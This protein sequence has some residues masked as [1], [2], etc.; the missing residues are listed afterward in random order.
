MLYLL[1]GCGSN[2][3]NN[4]PTITGDG[5]N[6]T[7]VSSTATV[8]ITDPAGTNIYSAA[9]VREIF[10][11]NSSVIFTAFSITTDPAL[12]LPLFSINPINGHLILARSPLA[13]DPST[14]TIQIT[15][16]S[17]NDQ[18]V[19]ATATLVINIDVGALTRT[20][21]AKST[22]FANTP[23][24]TSIYTASQ[25][26]GSFLN[27]GSLVFSTFS[28][29][30]TP[31]TINPLFT[32]N[33]TNGAITLARIPTLA[34]IATQTIAITAFNNDDRT[35]LSTATLVVSVQAGVLTR[36][37]PATATISTNALAGTSIY[38]ASQVSG[39][40]LNDG[41][42]VF[43]TFSISITPATIN[44]LFTI[45]STNGAITLVRSPEAADASTQTILITAFAGTQ[46][47]TS[48]LTVFV[49][50]SAGSLARVIPA[51]AT[52][53]TGNPVGT[54][55]YTA[56]QVSGSFLNDGSLVFSTFS[57]SITPATIN[58]LFTINSTNGA[59]TLARIPTLADIATQTIAIT[60][61]NNDDRTALSTATLVVSV[62][63][64]VLTRVIPA[65]ATI[66]T[67]AL[68]GTS[69]YTASQVS[70]SFLNDGS[71]NFS[72]FSIS[73]TPS[74]TNPLF[75]INATNGAITLVRSPEAADASTQTILITAFAGT[76]RLTSTLTVFV[77]VSAGSLAR[78]IPATATVFTGNPVGT[79]IYTASQVSGSF[80][81]DG[82]LVF[83][84][85]SISI[86]PA[87][88][89][90]LFTI[91][92]T[93][94]AITLAR[95]PTLADI[96][97]QTIAITA[98][99]NDDRT[100]LSTAT[101]VVSV[102]AGVLT[103]VIPATAT[104]STNALAGTSIYTASQVSGSF[105]NDGSLNFSTFS[106][107]VTPST[108]NPLF[109]IN[110]TNGAITLV[111]SPE[112]AD[113]STQTILITAF[114]GTQRL[115]S[116]LTVFVQV[117][118]GSLARVIPA[119]ATVFTDN[120]VGTPIY[121]A[122]QV[123]GSFLND[124][125]LVFSTF[126]ISI[127]PATINPLFTINS[128]NGAI[129]LARIPTL[130]DIAT[131]TIAITAF[132]N[133]D[134]TGL[135]TATLVVSVQAGVLT[136][137]IPAT[138]T[139][140]TNALAGTSIYT[141]S[142]VSGSFL[143]D[144]SLNFSTFSIS[145]TPSTTN[146]L[147][148]INATN[149][150]I[151][152]VRSPEA[153]DAST[154]TILITAFA[155]TQRL[156]ST[157]TVFVQVSAGSLARVIPAT[158]TV[159][160]G[161]PVGTPIYTASQVSGSF[162][163]DGSLVFSTFSISITPAT[164]NPLFTINST[165][166]AIT[167]ARIPTLADIAT[168][169]IA[170]TA[171]NNDD[172]T[173]LSTATLV[174]S[175]QAGTLTR[176][177]PATAT[178][179]TNAL[180]GASIYTAS[181]VSGSFLNDGSLNFSTFSISVTPSTTNPLFTINATN[182]AI[183]L[184][185]SPEAADA[186]TQTILITAFAGTQRLTS[187]LTV[188]VQVSA[189]SLARVIPATATVFTGNPV[190]T[191]IYTAS[192]VSGS[193]L[194]DGSLVFSTFSISITP[195]TINPLFTINSTNGAITLARIP[196]LADIAT[197]TIAITAFNNDDRTALSTATLVVSVLP[198]NVLSLTTGVKTI[199][200]SWEILPNSINHYQLLT[201]PEGT[202]GFIDL[203][204][205]GVIVSPNSTNITATTA[206]ARIALHK[207]FAIA[208]N[209]QYIVETCASVDNSN[210]ANQHTQ[211]SL[212]NAQV[213]SLIE[214]FSPSNLDFA[215]QF[216]AA[217]S[218]SSDGN[219]FVVGAFSEDGDSSS[220]MATPN[221]NALNSGAAYVFTRSGNTWTQT[222]YLKASNTGGGIPPNGPGDQFGVS[223]A[224]SAD[225]S[226]IVVG[227]P[228]EDG[229]SNSSALNPNE[230][231]QLAGAAYVFSRSGSVWSQTAYLKATNA[232][233]NAFF[234]RSV[235][236]NGDG[237]VLVV[238][239]NFANAFNGSAYVF[240]RSGSV[241]SQTAE[242]VASNPSVLDEFGLTVRINNAG[243]V[244]AIGSP[245]EDGSG[246]S[247]MAVPNDSAIDAGAVY[248]YARTST[249]IPSWT[250]TAYI[251]ASNAEGADTNANG[252]QFGRSIDFNADGSILV[253]NAQNED[254]S[255]TSTMAMPNNSSTDTGSAYVFN[256]SGPV[257]STTWTQTA[258]VKAP[259]ADDGDQFG[260]SVAI[261]GNSQILLIGTQQENSNAFSGMNPSSDNSLTNAGAAYTY[262]IDNGNIRFLSF[263]KARISANNEDFGNS[264]ALDH[265]GNNAIV[266]AP[267]TINALGVASPADF[268][269]LY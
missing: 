209:P 72:T 210:C 86:T 97:T 185:R 220:T 248:I 19:T 263:L 116:T 50:V 63:A 69:I 135:S 81:N 130:A 90:P 22:I 127:T 216:G 199:N 217:V 151:T 30:I 221:D 54:P 258:Y 108:T 34:D 226:I 188:F 174:V 198:S 111:R 227:A 101:L 6:S 120:P 239:A 37:I 193:F 17:I 254:G 68:A 49:Q 180:A 268:V 98:F 39:S 15:A 201:N 79:P 132:N 230:N 29:S 91:N 168:Q 3:G 33:S 152:L 124:G 172:R 223:V 74:T 71:L 238:G 179:S 187:T 156:T 167:L 232:S 253:V 204:T 235:S 96:A 245:N 170:I 158:A 25:V 104:I 234:G 9:Q 95:I 131:Q 195:A 145:V 73:V 247:S 44:P 8:S 246:T 67:N 144:G 52:V 18:T 182:G 56:S 208:N 228:A 150:A 84:T 105:L 214:Q 122:S 48:T 202:S 77:Q 171:F 41:S 173:A 70:G 4:N 260:N 213:R 264:A 27:D 88:I 244:I 53:F 252:D 237:S 205:N 249:T 106:I 94:G 35:A 2:N 129:T 159:F 229:D 224:I 211:R 42:L 75:T 203:S 215:D 251:K 55:I 154:Q 118:A 191:P 13:A 133:D 89:N 23:A 93:N 61:F 136:R 128:T 16:S 121:T 218:I 190:G 147:F 139:I 259:N 66:S 40:F 165:N 256:R 222:G 115:T 236:I 83:S 117:S 241:W 183:T 197:Q 99:N 257:T 82:S 78:V 5:A 51:T 125:S 231:A 140:S 62:Q 265:S 176:V 250:Q 100:A 255:S 26:S 153:A 212:T 112:A 43:S 169:T 134:R 59:I 21:P 200:F 113:A 102:Q 233:F 76:Q 186:S 46:R 85:F 157:L 36:V 92:S 161:N 47:L 181:Q 149:G 219:T 164:I 65:T 206:S 160:T 109:T 225:G 103:R 114:A 1:Q 45:N 163:N 31:A 196:T 12:T 57:I 123:S 14:H 10:S 148:T 137:V 138:A 267:G 243:T 119:T 240:S 269:T 146:P 126:S 262:A 87:T 20:I 184:V 24:G 7:T 162:L 261:S 110:A 141:A 166:G 194:N 178:I 143:N 177:I 64:G 28:I 175:V 142:Q 38:T 60:A 192:Q 80:L 189:G 32:I 242:L 107:S 58:P 11:N 266:G 207:Y 155:D